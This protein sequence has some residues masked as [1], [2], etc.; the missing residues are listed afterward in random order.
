[1]PR[2]LRHLKP[3]Y[4]HDIMWPKFLIEEHVLEW[5]ENHGTKDKFEEQV[6]EQFENHWIKFVLQVPGRTKVIFLKESKLGRKCEFTGFG[7]W[8][9]ERLRQIEAWLDIEVAPLHFRLNLH[10]LNI[11]GYLK[12]ASIML[13][14]RKFVFLMSV[15]LV[16]M[17][18]EKVLFDWSNAIANTRI[19]SPTLLPKTYIL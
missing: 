16:C 12:V 8:Q 5:F 11:R 15:F 7:N 13:W 18:I 3:Y 6:L 1:V 14:L 2:S 17:A 4:V 19:Q 10:K 9:N